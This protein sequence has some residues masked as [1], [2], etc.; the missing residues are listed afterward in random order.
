[1]VSGVGIPETFAKLG[2]AAQIL[3]PARIVNIGIA[4][5]YPESGLAIGDIVTAESECYGD[6]GFELPEE[7]GFQP[8]AESNFGAFYAD[9]LFL[10][11]LSPPPAGF[12]LRT[13]AGCTVNACAGTLRT[14][15]TRARLFRADFETMEGAAVAQIGIAR[16][17]PVTEI[18]AIS[19]LAAQRD[20]R[21]ENIRLAL[22]N[23][24]DFLQCLTLTPALSQ[25]WEREQELSPPSPRLGRRGPGG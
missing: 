23:L 10:T 20:M 12:N 1:M 6:V 14:G 25:I 5:A 22:A 19:N 7:P 11:P 24:R 8:I 13:G 4:G 17:I 16:H 21:P 3:N 9:K 2:A 18:R 15:E